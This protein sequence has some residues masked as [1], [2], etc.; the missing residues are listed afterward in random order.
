MIGFFINRHF[1]TLGL[2]LGFILLLRAQKSSGDARYRYFWL[3]VI[4]TL[5][6]VA[7]DCMECWAQLA[8]ERI[9]LRVAFS[10]ISYTFRPL[11]ALGITMVLYP[12][13]HRPRYIWIPAVVNMLVYC[14]A[15]FSPVAFCYDVSN[16]FH[17]GPLGFTVYIV[18]CFYVLCILWLKQKRFRGRGK[19]GAI[20]YYCAILCLAAAAADYFLEGSL[21]NAAV[22]MSSIFMYMF[23]RSFEINRDPLTKLWNRLAFYEDCDRNGA[24]ISA[25]ALADMNGLKQVNDDLGHE[26]GDRALKSIGECLLQV[27]GNQTTAYRIGGDEFVL[28][29]IRQDEQAVQDTLDRLRTMIHEKGLSISA[30]YVMRKGRED[31]VRDM[32]RWAD[33]EM[34]REK[35]AYYRQ[36]G[37]NRRRR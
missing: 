24:A 30:G 31:T 22:M 26:A 36:R 12:G 4:S 34:Y 23:L 8:V 20:L 9:P 19:E 33:E 21:I 35:S 7:A 14:T 1:I 27:S 29:F 37:H 5:V 17:R 18:C 10:I 25:V 13:F 2:T 6:L 28:L 32:I 11:A 15:I 3:T 16:H